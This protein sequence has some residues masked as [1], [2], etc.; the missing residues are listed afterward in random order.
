MVGP[1]L[2]CIVGRDEHNCEPRSIG[3]HIIQ[4]RIEVFSP[5]ICPFVA[6]VEDPNPF[7]S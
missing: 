7:D 3:I 4:M 5:E 1:E 6:I 2:A